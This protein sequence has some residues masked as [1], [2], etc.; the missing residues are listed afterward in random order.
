M[1]RG[2]VLKSPVFYG[3]FLKKRRGGRGGAPLVSISE[4]ILNLMK[5]IYLFCFWFSWMSGFSR[6]ATKVADLAETR[7]SKS[8]P[9]GG[10]QVYAEGLRV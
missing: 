6:D 8:S 7:E 3:V 4:F 10:L 5:T 1:T 9:G 2:A